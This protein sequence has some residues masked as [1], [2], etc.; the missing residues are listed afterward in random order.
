MTM[1]HTFA[2]AWALGLTTF[3]LAQAPQT[4]VGIYDARALL[5]PVP[6]KERSHRLLPLQAAF[7]QE[8]AVGPIWDWEHHETIT[9]EHLVEF[10]R[11]AAKDPMADVS[12][13]AGWITVTGPPSVQAA[14]AAGLSGLTRDLLQETTVEV[15]ALP[16]GEGPGGILGA[17]DAGRIVSAPGGPALLGQ[18][19]LV[20]GQH[21]RL[22]AGRETS[23]VADYDVEVA[24]DSAIAAPLIRELREG[25]DLQ[26]VVGQAADGRLILR[27][28]CTRSALAEPLATRTVGSEKVGDVQL[29]KV[30][31]SIVVASGLVEDGGAVVA[32]HDGGL[33]SGVLVRVQRKDRG[34]ATAPAGEQQIVFADDLL[35]HRLRVPVP[36][37]RSPRPEDGEPPADMEIPHTL[38]PLPDPPEPISK[39]TFVDL[40]RA[41]AREESGMHFELVGSRVYVRAPE[42]KIARVREIVTALGKS[43]SRNVAVE[44]RIGKTDLSGQALAKPEDLAA[45]LP[46]QA[47]VTA[48]ASDQFLVAAGLEQSALL[49][50]DVEIAEKSKIADPR[51]GPLF[52]GYV[53]SGVVSSPGGDRIELALEVSHDEILPMPAAGFQ[54][55]AD[56]LGS[57]DLPQVVTT[58]G[59]FRLMLEPGRW[60]VVT[61]ATPGEGPTVVVLARA[62]W[63]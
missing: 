13:S 4:T 54:L 3:A 34:P 40:I 60:T 45:K 10:L 17:A 47:S 21:G 20:L 51:V 29:P 53:I 39:D 24:Q 1:R 63:Q 37:T 6:V 23:F 44:F 22:R 5:R 9:T 61:G 57:V 30:R 49:G 26:A 58:G 36:R 43:F 33:G 38:E 16:A 31:S 35:S 28:G 27:F 15:W 18:M 14:V 12:V 55:R 7:A 25:L 11:H 42:E 32:R 59:T 52:D 46:A 8:V 56:A 48:S 41:G 19:T 62:R 50:H 2:A